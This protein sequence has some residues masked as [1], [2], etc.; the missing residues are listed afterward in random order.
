MFCSAPRNSKN[1][2]IHKNLSWFP[3]QKKMRIFRRSRAQIW[4]LI[5]I[6]NKSKNLNRLKTA[7]AWEIL[8]IFSSPGRIPETISKQI[9]TIMKTKNYRKLCRPWNSSTALKS[10]QII[11]EIRLNK[12]SKIIHSIRIWVWCRFPIILSKTIISMN[13][14][15]GP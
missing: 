10:S 1:R 6:G 8:K 14:S 13:S 2:W 11:Q 7:S 9:T 4:D 3:S 5:R 15:S 12:Y